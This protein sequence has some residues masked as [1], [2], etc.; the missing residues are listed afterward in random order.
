MI[1]AE[2]ASL[3]TVLSASLGRKQRRRG[4]GE[5]KGQDAE[6]P[7]PKTTRSPVDAVSF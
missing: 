7:E 2:I 1:G 6:A 5:S 3:D 4:R